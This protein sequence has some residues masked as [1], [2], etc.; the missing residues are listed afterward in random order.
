[1]AC[2]SG[3]RLCMPKA[4][5][6]PTQT[7]RLAAAAEVAEAANIHFERSADF[8]TIYSNFF[9]TRTGNGDF[10]LIFSRITHTPGLDIAGNI[11]EEQAEIIITWQQLKILTGLL[12][13]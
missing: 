8:K 11:M 6:T 9:R 3:G 1:M 7:E 10:S 4:P 12:M 13:T 2:R 5:A